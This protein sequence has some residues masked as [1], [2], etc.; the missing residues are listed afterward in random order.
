MDN[1]GQ[2]WEGLA[3]A[4]GFMRE[5]RA[6]FVMGIVVRPK[7]GATNVA[8]AQQHP[9]LPEEA[10]HLHAYQIPRGA[11]TATEMEVSAAAPPRR[12]E[13][14]VGHFSPYLRWVLTAG[15]SSL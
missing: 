7:G 5:T 15:N 11:M 14:G 12:G 13:G 8:N 4:A 3:A 1:N 9:L 6:N 2:Q 10:R